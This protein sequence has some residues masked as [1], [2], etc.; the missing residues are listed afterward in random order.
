MSYSRKI[1]TLVRFHSGEDNVNQLKLRAQF[2]FPW[3]RHLTRSKDD[4]ELWISVVT[5]RE[6]PLHWPICILTVSLHPIL[7]YM[8]ILL[9]IVWMWQ[10]EREMVESVCVCMC[11]FLFCNVVHCR[12]KFSLFLWGSLCP[13]ALLMHT[14]E[15]ICPHL[16][17]APLTYAV[18]SMLNFHFRLQFSTHIVWVGVD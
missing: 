18:F 12:W 2:V 11:I 5:L 7:G 17:A 6:N 3:P 16:L 1:T 14:S 10:R 15:W 9:N 8:V 13:I 4:P